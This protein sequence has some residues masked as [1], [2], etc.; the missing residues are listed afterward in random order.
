MVPKF[1]PSATTPGTGWVV[2]VFL[3]SL[4][5]GPQPQELE[6]YYSHNHYQDLS[7]VNTYLVKYSVEYHTIRDSHINLF[8]LYTMVKGDLNVGDHPL[9]SVVTNFLVQKVRDLKRV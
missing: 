6:D 5:L 2:L 4:F 7:V 9:R 3:V 8:F 1:P